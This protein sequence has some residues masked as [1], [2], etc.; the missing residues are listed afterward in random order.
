MMISSAILVD[1]LGR[2]EVKSCYYVGGKAQPDV[3]NAKR[4]KPH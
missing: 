4:L 2:R 1:M 3:N